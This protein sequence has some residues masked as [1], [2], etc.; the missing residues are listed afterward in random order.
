VWEI[1]SDLDTHLCSASTRISKGFVKDVDPYKPGAGNLCPQ[2]PKSNEPRN[3]KY[4]KE[5]A[6]VGV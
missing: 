1:E 6:F 3:L 5:K 2:N 4:E